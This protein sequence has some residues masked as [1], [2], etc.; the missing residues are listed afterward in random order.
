MDDFLDLPP[1]NIARNSCGHGW[2]N[3]LDNSFAQRSW[4]HGLLGRSF[5]APWRQSKQTS[6]RAVAF[7]RR[8]CHHGLLG[9]RL[10]APWRQ[11]RQTS[12]R[13]VAFALTKGFHRPSSLLNHPF[14]SAPTPAISRTIG[15]RLRRSFDTCCR[16]GIPRLTAWVIPLP[17]SGITMSGFA[18]KAWTIV[19]VGR[20]PARLAR[21]SKVKTRS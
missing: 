5:V 17:R 18:P 13:A 20:P 8:S 3:L 10:V 4:H 7:S 19:A 14:R 15:A 12:W 1:K 9:R 2:I 11:F 21:L 16:A 6:W